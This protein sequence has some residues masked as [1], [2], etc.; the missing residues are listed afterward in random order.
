VAQLRSCSGTG[1]V[2]AASV[3]GR[4]PGSEM[5]TPFTRPPRNRSWR[6]SRP[7]AERKNPS[8]TNGTEEATRVPAAIGV[9]ISH[10]GRKRRRVRI[11][12]SP[13]RESRREA[14]FSPASFA[15]GG[16][17]LPGARHARL[18]TGGAAREKRRSRGRARSLA[19]PGRERAFARSPKGIARWPLR[20]ETA[21]HECS[22]WDGFGV[23]KSIGRIAGRDARGTLPSAPR[24]R[25]T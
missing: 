1:G 11:V 16:P 13:K 9:S 6:P 17:E 21:K 5:R 14:R 10:G 3:G 24:N 23:Q 15:S 20:R 8:R 22:S 2:C 12:R 25:A 19:A 7:R 18:R 4:H